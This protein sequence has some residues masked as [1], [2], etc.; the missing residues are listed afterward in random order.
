MHSL[1]MSKKST[2]DI[3]AEIKNITVIVSV[4][5]LNEFC[6]VIQVGSGNLCFI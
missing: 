3:F 1:V 2:P 4:L 6:D 5:F